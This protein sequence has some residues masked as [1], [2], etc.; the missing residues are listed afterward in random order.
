[1]QYTSVLS[2]LISY[3]NY[4]FWQQELSADI[5][6]N[7]FPEDTIAEKRRNNASWRCRMMIRRVEEQS[8]KIQPNQLMNTDDN[9]RKPGQVMQKSNNQSNNNTRCTE[10]TKTKNI[11]R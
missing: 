2:N 9:R 3:N 11:R 7:L 5:S 1:M 6:H 4:N 10:T 8:P